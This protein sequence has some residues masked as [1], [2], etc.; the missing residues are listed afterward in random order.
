MKIMILEGGKNRHWRAV[1]VPAPSYPKNDVILEDY[2]QQLLDL[3]MQTSSTFDGCVPMAVSPDLLTFQQCKT[4]KPKNIYILAIPHQ[5]NHPSYYHQ[6][7]DLKN[8]LY[9]KN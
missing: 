9:F 6:H 1:C 7:Y 2:I 3:E 8:L 4:R 5:H